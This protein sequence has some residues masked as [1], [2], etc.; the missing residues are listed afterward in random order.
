MALND[1]KELVRRFVAAIWNGEETDLASE[2]VHPDYAVGEGRGPDAVIASAAVYRTAFPDMRWE[3]EQLIAEGEWVAAR[4]TLT[5]THLGPFGEI[6]PTGRRVLMREMI[7]W[8]VVDGKL[9]TV[10]AQADALGLRV[11]LGAIP[12]SA[13]RRSLANSEE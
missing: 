7:F 11:Q 5:G 12:A 2:L 9:H 4:L 10:W 8:R 1:N 13:W 3:I 6:A